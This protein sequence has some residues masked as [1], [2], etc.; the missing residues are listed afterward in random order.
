MA[1]NMTLTADQAAKF[2]PMYDQFQKEQGAM[3]G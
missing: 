3:P 2:W 1:K